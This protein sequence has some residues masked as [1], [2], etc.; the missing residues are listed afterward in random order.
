[1]K[2]CYAALAWVHSRFSPILEEF[3]DYIA[4]PSRTATSRCT[5]IVRDGAGRPIEIQI[6]TQAMHEHAE[7]GVARHW[8]YKE[9]GQ[10]GYAGVA[11]A[12]TTTAKIA[13]AAP[14]AGVGARPGRLRRGLFEDRIYVLTPQASDRRAAARARRRWTSPT[15]CTPAW[16]TAAAARA[17]TARWCR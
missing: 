17:S 12:A 7:H 6:R 5:P 8:A 15:R 14:A 16:A 1:V 2:D 10:K 4:G 9:A 11:P 13:G 3:D